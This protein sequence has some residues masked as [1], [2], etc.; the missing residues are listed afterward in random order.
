MSEKR[1]RVLVNVAELGL[2]LP[3]LA[4][5]WWGWPVPLLVA[6]VAV[7]IVVVAAALVSARRRT[8]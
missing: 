1:H 2:P 4:G 8:R 3:I 7:W 5:L 6:L